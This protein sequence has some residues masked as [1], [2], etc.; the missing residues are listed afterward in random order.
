MEDDFIKKLRERYEKGEISRETYE[1]ILRRYLDEVEEEKAEE[2]PEKIREE[3]EYENSTM[4][5]I[6]DILSR[7][8]EKMDEELKNFFQGMRRQLPRK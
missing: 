7:A 8:M 1:D 4:G 5:G 3:G 2:E 6:D